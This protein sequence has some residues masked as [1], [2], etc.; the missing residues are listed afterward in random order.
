[1]IENPSH[2]FLVCAI[3]VGL[4]W[5][6]YNGTYRTLQAFY[7]IPSDI[8]YRRFFFPRIIL[9]FISGVIISVATQGSAP[10]IPMSLIGFAVFLTVSIYPQ[11]VTFANAKRYWGDNDS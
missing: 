1:M 9:I 5:A 7:R 6:L 3:T 8:N 10:N 4:D 11:A 2:T